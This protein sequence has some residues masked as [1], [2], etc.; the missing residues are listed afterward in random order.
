MGQNFDDYPG[1]QQI[2]GMSYILTYSCLN[3]FYN[4]LVFW[5]FNV[6][7]KNRCKMYLSKFI[8]FRKLHENEQILRSELTKKRELLAKLRQELEY[9]RET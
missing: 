7:T 5:Y 8:N 9:P 2:P 1:F 3:L 4:A 6:H